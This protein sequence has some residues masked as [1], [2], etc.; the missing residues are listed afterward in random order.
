MDVCL[1]ALP[2][3]IESIIDKADSSSNNTSID[4]RTSA[5]AAATQAVSRNSENGTPRRL[6]LREIRKQ[7]PYRKLV[8]RQ[9]GIRARYYQQG[10]GIYRAKLPRETF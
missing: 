1:I 8:A 3:S 10:R 4:H 5:V 6:D 7:R 9:R 2:R